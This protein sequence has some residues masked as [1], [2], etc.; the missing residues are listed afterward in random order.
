MLALCEDYQDML[1]FVGLDYGKMERAC[2]IADYDHA[3]R[4]YWELPPNDQGESDVV[5]H[6]KI[7]RPPPGKKERE[8]L[9]MKRLPRGDEGVME[10]EIVACLETMDEMTTQADYFALM[11]KLRLID[12]SF[13]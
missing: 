7:H 1:E 6:H 2:L 4:T 3:G 10:G 9:G 5:V 13:Q 12:T 8:A 11:K